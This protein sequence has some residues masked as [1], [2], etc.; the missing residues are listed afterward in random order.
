MLLWGKCCSSSTPPHYCTSHIH[1]YTSFALYQRSAAF[2]WQNEVC[3]V[4]FLS[5][6]VLC[7]S[8]LLY[9]SFFIYL[10]R[11]SNAFYALA[12]LT[13]FL[14]CL[15][16]CSSS[17]TDSKRD[18]SPL[19]QISKSSNCSPAHRAHQKQVETSGIQENHPLAP[20]APQDADKPASNGVVAQMEQDVEKE[21]KEKKNNESVRTARM[22][23]GDIG[24]G[25]TEQSDGHSS[26][27]T[28]RTG[29]E[30]HTEN[31]DCGTGTESEHRNGDEG[32]DHKVRA[33][34]LVVVLAHRLLVQSVPFC[35][36]FGARHSFLVVLTLLS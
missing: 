3:A 34:L 5:R 27:Q 23:N 25:G 18:S 22:V 19:K 29:T 13:N 6:T 16:L 28:D 35:F 9:L 20:T 33:C 8:S 14:H 2:M 10:F 12:G 31:E 30:S 21:N 7:K 15:F 1:I 36:I 17:S 11:L 4:L 32:A 24:E 26:P